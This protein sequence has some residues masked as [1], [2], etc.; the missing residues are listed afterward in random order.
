MLIAACTRSFTKN[1]CDTEMNGNANI[2]FNELLRSALAHHREGRLDAAEGLYRQALKLESRHHDA[3]RLL[4]VVLHQRRHLDD[5]QDI[6]EQAVQAPPVSDEARRELASVYLESSI[7]LIGENKLAKA[8]AVLCRLIALQPDHDVAHLNL[9]VALEGLERMDEAEQVAQKALQ[10]SPQNP[11][12]HLFLGALCMKRDRLS[13]AA[14]HLNHASQLDPVSSAAAISTLRELLRIGARG[15]EKLLASD[16]QHFEA[17]RYLGKIRFFE[18]RPLEAIELLERALVIQ[19]GDP[20][21]EYNL[22]FSELITGRF[23][24]GWKHY[25][26]RLR[27]GQKEFLQREFAEQRWTGEPVHGRRILVHAEQ[28]TGDT[29]QFVRYIPLVAERGGTVIFECQRSLVPLLRDLPGASAI[30]AQGE[31]LPE[32]ELQVPLLSL[33]GI[34]QTTLATI[35]NQAPYLKVPDTVQV[36]LPA[37]PPGR[38]RIGIV[39]AG[40]PSMQIDLD[41]SMPL[42]ALAPLWAEGTAS[43]FSLQVGPAAAQLACLPE[44][45]AIMDLRPIL[46]NYAATAAAIEQ[47]DLVITVCTSVAHLAGALGKRTWVL[48][49]YGADWR[50]LLD[51]SDSPWY[52]TMRL[53]RQKRLHDWNSVVEEAAAELAKEFAANATSGPVQSAAARI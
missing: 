15:W 39:W 34:F 42:S 6:L 37:T 18:R 47:L 51:R 43:F 35:P 17:L 20:H 7:A 52:P 16:P 41:R 29:I 22:A 12:A 45:S 24:S 53:F 32:F 2:S 48:L 4:G 27:T 21:T 23:E 46:I 8:A 49:S 1:S 19:P 31:P 5:A 33:P 13:D 36:Q 26:S 3:L 11:Q 10:L 44:G 14:P 9:A 28:G 38:L 50:W 25:E 40:N 30:I